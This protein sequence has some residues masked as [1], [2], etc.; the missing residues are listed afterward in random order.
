MKNNAKFRIKMLSFVL[1]S[2]LFSVSVGAAESEGAALPKEY[3]EVLDEL[4]DDY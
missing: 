4:P 3:Y 1:L 2:V